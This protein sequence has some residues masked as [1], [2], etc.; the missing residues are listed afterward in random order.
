VATANHHISSPF[1][2]SI[3][4][5]IVFSTQI[6]N[7]ELPRCA[8]HRLLSRRAGRV[9][10]ANPSGESDLKTEQVTLTCGLLSFSSTA[11]IASLSA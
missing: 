7:D 6:S 11:E 2:L 8:H 5:I 10:G 4:E 3:L 1:I 9:L